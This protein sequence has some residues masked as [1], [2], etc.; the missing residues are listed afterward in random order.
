MEYSSSCKAKRTSPQ[1]AAMSTYTVKY[2]RST[3]H[4]DGIAA[5]CTST[6]EERGGVVASYAQNA[7]GVLTRGR[8]ATGKSYR[9]IQEAYDAASKHT[10]RICKTCAKAALALIAAEAEQAEVDALAEAAH[11]EFVADTPQHVLGAEHPVDR[12][13]TRLNSRH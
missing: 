5:K 1:E 2:N 10:R 6:G 12:K 9:T 8:L 7:C 3:N 11:E 4:I 13:S